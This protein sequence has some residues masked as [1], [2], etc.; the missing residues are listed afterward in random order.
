MRKIGHRLRVERV[1]P[2]ANRSGRRIR[3]SADNA[4]RA[5]D[6]KIDAR[7]H[8]ASRN[9]GHHTD[10]RLKQ[11]RSV[12]DRPCMALTQNHLR[13]CTRR[14]ERMK[15][16]D[17]AAG[18]GDEAKRKNLPRENWTASVDE[19]RKRRHYHVGPDEQNSR[20]KRKNGSR[21]DERAEII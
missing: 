4:R 19:S 18:D 7:G 1:S 5:V 9:H 10:K 17:R 12:T 14:N 6:R 2:T 16:A 15:S 8:R 13:R 3:S 20:R 11:H 21:L